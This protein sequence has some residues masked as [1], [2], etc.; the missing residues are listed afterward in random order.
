MVIFISY[1]YTWMCCFFSNRIV[2][3]FIGDCCLNILIPPK[4]FTLK[5]SNFLSCCFGI[6][7][8]AHLNDINQMSV[9]FL[10]FYVCTRVSI[11]ATSDTAS[12]ECR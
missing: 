10:L 1:T 7:S 2:I 5:N 9:L 4:R 11:A 8:L 6:F 12:L 3:L